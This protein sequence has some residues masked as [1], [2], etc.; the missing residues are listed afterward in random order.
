[1]HRFCFISKGQILRAFQNIEKFVIFSK[2]HDFEK[3]MHSYVSNI[4]FNRPLIL[5]LFISLERS[6]RV[7]FERRSREGE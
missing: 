6:E 4:G 5:D 7:I 1:M 2:K 3:G